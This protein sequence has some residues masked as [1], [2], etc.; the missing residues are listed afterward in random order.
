MT[1]AA[2]GID[3]LEPPSRASRA[4]ADVVFFSYL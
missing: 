3:G 4:R 1:I 2:I